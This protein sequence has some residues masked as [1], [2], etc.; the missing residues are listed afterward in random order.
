MIID[1]MLKDVSLLI[2]ACQRKTTDCEVPKLRPEHRYRLT[3][4]IVTDGVSGCNFE[5]SYFLFFG[6]ISEKM[7][8]GKL[9]QFYRVY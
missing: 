6:R 4:Y 7:L 8:G 5:G 1:D 2:K 3:R 9:R